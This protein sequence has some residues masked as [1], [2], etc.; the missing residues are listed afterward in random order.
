MLTPLLECKKD[1]WDAREFHKKV[2]GKGASVVLA[3]CRG[4]WIG[5]V[6]CIVLYLSLFA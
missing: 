1:G 2:D 4:Q 5:G 3:K 6:R